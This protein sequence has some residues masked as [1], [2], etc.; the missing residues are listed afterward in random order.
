MKVGFY[1]LEIMLF[2]AESLKDKRRVMKSITERV[3]RRYNVSISEVGEQD[4]KKKAEIGIAAVSG[5]HLSV[6]RLLQKVFNFIEED[7]RVEVVD[8]S[9]QTV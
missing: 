9:Y 3:R 7:G 5:D 4:N 2:D 1:F 6:D 8:Y